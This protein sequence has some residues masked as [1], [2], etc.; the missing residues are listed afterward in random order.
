GK[1]KVAPGAYVRL[2]VKDNGCGMD[3]EVKQRIFEPFFTTKPV[4]EG[5]GMGLAVVHGILSSHGAAVTVDSELGR[6]TT[7]EVYFPSYQGETEETIQPPTAV[8]N[9]RE[10]ILMVDD[11][12][13]LVKIAKELLQGLGYDVTT[14]TSSRDAFEHFRKNPNR[15]D[16]VLT[17]Q[18][19]PELTGMQL[20]KK[21]LAIR[22]DIPIILVTGYSES[23][24]AA[25]VREAGIRA[26]LMKPFSTYELGGAIRKTLES[27]AGRSA[28]PG[29]ADRGDTR[30]ARTSASA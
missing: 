1:L 27:R 5:S 9:G 29:R 21:L 7:F 11:E 8:R 13:D 23:V 25:R 3:E 19:M 17:D 20:S 4:G 18:T 15:Y 10:T 28:H 22:G 12:H 6:G 14:F 2:I 24:T 30:A 26:L 16:L